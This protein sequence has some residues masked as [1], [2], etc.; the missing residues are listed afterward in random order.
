VDK[1]IRITTTEKVNHPVTML[2]GLIKETHAAN[3]GI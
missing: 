1:V 3:K 2:I